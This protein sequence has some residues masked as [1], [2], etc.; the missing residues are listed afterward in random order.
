[1]IYHVYSI[2]SL[3]LYIYICI[4]V[5]TSLSLSLSLFLSLSLYIYIYIHIFIMPVPF[6]Q[7]AADFHRVTYQLLFR[8]K[9][10]ISSLPPLLGGFGARAPGGGES[11]APQP[12][13]ERL[14]LPQAPPGDRGTPAARGGNPRRARDATA[15]SPG[16][17]L[18]LDLLCRSAG[19]GGRAGFSRHRRALPA[20]WLAA[21]LAAWPDTP[22]APGGPV[23]H[24][25]RLAWPPCL[26]SLL[27][28][29]RL[30]G[31][32]GR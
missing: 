31:P 9:R 20:A 19:P 27:G 16:A 11:A 25:A 30:P 18:S 28:L 6:R 10:I 3:S 2:L 12:Q 32:P 24:I 17:N 7:E 22:G 21:W 4:Y 15:R 29:P 14:S 13:Q 1:M 5:Y 26:A 8:S 23:A